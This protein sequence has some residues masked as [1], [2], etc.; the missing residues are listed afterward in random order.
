LKITF[1]SAGSE[2]LSKIMQG[3]DEKYRVS[4]AFQV[5]PVMI[6]PTVPPRYALPV[7]YV[8]APGDEGVL[9]LPTLGPKLEAIRPNKFVVGDEITLIGLDIG[10][11]IEEIRLGD[12]AFPVVAA[13]PG[14]IKAVISI[15]TTLSAGSYPVRAVRHLPGDKHFSSNALLGH[16]LPTFED[17]SV[18]L[19]NDGGNVSGVLTI[20]G[21]RL[22]EPDD[23]IFVA[24]YRNGEVALMLEVEGSAAQTTLTITV[25]GNDALPEGD[26]Y[27]ILR[28][29]GEQAT[30]APKVDWS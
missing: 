19:T 17:F 4:V 27:I 16:L 14:E 29:N 18:N 28:V 10:T 23:S 11:G 5:R 26:Y 24:F 13:K 8:G 20:T 3:T 21:N 25:D 22:G 6:I 30:N 15:D 2:L 7:K 1:D 12:T 9:V